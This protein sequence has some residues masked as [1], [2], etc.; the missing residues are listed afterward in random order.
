MPETFILMEKFFYCKNKRCGWVGT[1]Q[2]LLWK[3][4]DG[5]LEHQRKTCPKCGGHWFEEKLIEYIKPK[6]IPEP[7]E[8]L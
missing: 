5:L 8:P 7:D 1:W 3:A 2:Q 6:P 4:D